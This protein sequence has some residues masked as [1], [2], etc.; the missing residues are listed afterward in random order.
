MLRR[1]HLPFSAMHSF[2]SC[3]IFNLW[4]QSSCCL[5]SYPGPSGERRAWYPLFAHA[6]ISP[7]F[8]GNRILL[9]YI[10]ATLK[11]WYITINGWSLQGT[12]TQPMLLLSVVLFLCP[13]FFRGPIDVLKEELRAAIKAV[14]EG[15]DV[16]VCLSAYW[17]RQ[18][19]VL[20]N[21][22]FLFSPTSRLGQLTV[23]LLRVSTAAAK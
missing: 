6:S 19:F 12:A 7:L 16:F 8:R 15:K 1:L 13:N 22:A 11:T 17:L 10:V 21:S 18:E 23:L 14:Y 5:A 9:L 4:I 3:V 20:L 2:R